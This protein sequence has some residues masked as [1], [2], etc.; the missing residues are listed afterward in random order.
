MVRSCGGRLF[1]TIRAVKASDYS[2][3][4]VLSEKEDTSVLK[5]FDV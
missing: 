3:A 2:P 1:K 4:R 5:N